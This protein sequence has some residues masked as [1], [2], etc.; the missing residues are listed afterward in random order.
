MDRFVA[1]STDWQ[2]ASARSSCLLP[3]IL[4]PQCSPEGRATL[5]CLLLAEGMESLQYRVR[6]HSSILV[7]WLNDTNC[8]WQSKPLAQCTH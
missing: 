1:H 5:F 8:P 6:P 2:K 7:L 3:R 4:K